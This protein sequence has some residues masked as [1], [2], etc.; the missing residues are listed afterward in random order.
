MRVS[1]RQTVTAGL[2]IGH[3]GGPD[4]AA[5]K[6]AETAL[7]TLKDEFAG[8]MEGDVKLLIAARTRY[9]QKPDAGTRSGLLRAAHDIMGQAPT[10]QY[11]MIARVAAS[12]WRLIGKLPPG[13]ALPLA[14]VDAH[15]GAIRAMHK[16]GLQDT[17]DRT[18]Q[19]LC[20]ALDARVDKILAAANR[21]G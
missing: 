2:G 7:D 21:P 17:K 4:M 13:A 18:A 6:R 5:I 16:K 8:W 19:D 15:V 3:G 9:A 12:L 20:A 11:P 10:F 14:L 1:S